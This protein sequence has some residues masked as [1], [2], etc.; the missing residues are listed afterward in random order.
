MHACN[1]YTLTKRYA[2]GNE[3]KTTTTKIAI[4]RHSRS[5]K[6]RNDKLQQRMYNRSSWSLQSEL[7]VAGAP[8]DIVP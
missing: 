3:N 5:A 8:V 2:T 7:H 6:A 1:V 4:E